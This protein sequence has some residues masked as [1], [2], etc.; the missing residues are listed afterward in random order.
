MMRPKAVM[1]GKVY[2]DIRGG[3]WGEGEF[4]QNTGLNDCSNL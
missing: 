2:G 3:K 1:E 4:V